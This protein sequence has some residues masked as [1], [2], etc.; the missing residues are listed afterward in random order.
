M[1][2]DRP[3]THVQDAPNQAVDRADTPAGHHGRPGALG[4]RHVL[5]A[6][7]QHR[8]HPPGELR[9]RPGRRGDEGGD[10][11]DGLG[12]AVRDRWRGAASAGAVRRVSAGVRA[13]PEDRAEQH[14]PAG[15]AGDGRRADA[16]ATRGISA[17]PTASS[18]CRP[19]RN[20][21]GHDS[22]S[23]SCCRRSATSSARPTRCSTSIRRTWRRGSARR[24]A[25]R[26]VDPADGPGAGGRRGHRDGGRPGPEPV[27]PAADPGGDRRGPRHDGRE[28]RP[29]RARPARDELGELANAFNEMARTIRD[30]ARPGPHGCSG[31]RRPPR[32]RSTRF[33]IR[34]WWS[35]RPA[36][37]SRPTRR[38]GESWAW[39]RR[40]RLRSRGSR[41]RR[42][43]PG[44]PT[45]SRGRGDYLPHSASSRRS[46][47]RDGGQERYFLPRVL[48]IRGDHDELLGAAVALADVTKFHLL[49]RLKSDMVS[50]VSHE[51][52]TPLTSVQMAIHLLL[53][54]V[55]G[56]LTPKQVEL[57]LAARQ[58]ADRILTM[59]NDLLDLTRIEQGRR[60]ARPPA[61]ARRPTWSTRPSTG[62]RSRA[63]DAGITL[64]ADVGDRPARRCMV[65]RDRIEHVFDNLI[66]NA[67]QHTAAGAR[68][69]RGRRRRRRARFVGR[70]HRRGIPA[71]H[72]PRHLREVLPGTRSTARP[73]ARGWAWR[74]SAR[75]SPPTAARSTS[76]SEPGKGTTFTFTL[77]TGPHTGD[78]SEQH[79]G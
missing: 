50:T 16:A 27:D 45:C 21:N 78:A 35:T 12:A 76:T 49:D 30:S 20:R 37:S 6:G 32:R 71:E 18:P 61:G 53:E 34:S 33:P 10:R 73:A 69:R 24:R 42:C 14:H 5:P 17:W 46:R 4:D 31:R 54:E 3:T 25:R 40:R 62:S 22:T 68:S 7:E 39:S 66:V 43:K 1:L 74:S 65:D 19:S 36:R 44:S 63:E 79:G 60:Q 57:L 29:A 47:F 2:G 70:G 58:D 28:P 56:P 52:K 48:A 77:P 41:R 11:A 72:L 59:I 26:R 51:L 9:E 13:E 75:S 23:R 15:R 38:R 67:I 64:E 8:R 55:V